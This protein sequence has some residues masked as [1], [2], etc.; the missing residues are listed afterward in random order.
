MASNSQPQL[1]H[2]L[3][4]SLGQPFTLLMVYGLF[5]LVG[6]TVHMSRGTTRGPL[7]ITFRV[8]SLV[9]LGGLGFNSQ[10]DRHYGAVGVAV[11][12]LV[13]II[14]SVLLGMASEYFRTPLPVMVEPPVEG[15][16]PPPIK[17]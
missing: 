9:T 13:Y 8:L 17:K 15:T 4:H 3:L 6:T 11:W 1:F 5:V 2:H 12:F 7:S 10:V 14:T 16:W